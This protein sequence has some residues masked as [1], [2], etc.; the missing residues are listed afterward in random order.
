MFDELDRLRSNPRLVELL[1]HY[2]RLGE[3]DREVWQDRLMT[4]EGVEAPEL[5]R[6]HGELIAHRWVD[7][8]TGVVPVAKAGEV[9]GC[10]RITA[11][12]Q[13]AL[14]L[15]LGLESEEEGTGQEVP[16]KATIKFP[17][18]KRKTASEPPP[19]APPVAA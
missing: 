18:K 15:A 17:K 5:V 7:Q 19:E 3:P 16:E 2:A 9:P 6:L 8:N 14:R 13:K 12:G 11:A 10:Y 1:S 4:M